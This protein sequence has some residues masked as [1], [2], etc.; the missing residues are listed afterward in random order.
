MPQLLAISLPVIDATNYRN[1]TEDELTDGQIKTLL[2]L[3]ENN[4]ENFAL[5]L[6]KYY[7]FLSD[8]LLRKLIMRV[9]QTANG[10]DALLTMLRSHAL[11]SLFYEKVTNSG[12]ERIKGSF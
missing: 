7:Y 5:I 11:K 10:P 6:N 2:L 3:A 8:K 9:A 12:L 1:W 4:S